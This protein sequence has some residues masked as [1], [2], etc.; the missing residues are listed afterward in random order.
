MTTTHDNEAAALRR[1]LEAK[2]GWQF[3]D[4]SLPGT[5]AII[6]M[7]PI[8]PATEVERQAFSEY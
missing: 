7:G 2:A 4:T 3:I 8:L 5:R 6:I 1:E